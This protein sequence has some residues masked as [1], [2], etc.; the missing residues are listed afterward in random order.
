MK[1]VLMALALLVFAVS[2]FGQ[3]EQAKA[4]AAAKKEQQE[5]I[6]GPKLK[7]EETTVDYGEIDQ[8]ADP[9]R[10]FKFTNVGNAP[11]VILN[12]KGSCG[13]TVPDAPKEPIAPGESGEIKVRYDTKRV[14]PFTKTVTL[15]TNEA[16]PTRTLIIK[17]K[18]NKPAEGLPKK[19][20]SMFNG[21]KS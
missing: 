5:T 20:A 14:G 17:G 4:E 18:V 19:K 6:E 11:A 2:A 13:C 10:V 15:T 9:Y 7:F 12:S 8:N 1:K 21:S 3:T 16:N